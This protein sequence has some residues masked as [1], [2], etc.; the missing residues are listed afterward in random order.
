[1]YK[2]TPSIGHAYELNAPG[3]A[4]CKLSTS[5]R[6]SVVG[7]AHTVKLQSNSLLRLPSHSN[8]I[9][10]GFSMYL[11]STTTKTNSANMLSFSNFAYKETPKSNQHFFD[12]KMSW[13]TV[14]EIW[15][16]LLCK[17]HQ[18]HFCNTCLSEDFLIGSER[19]NRMAFDIT[20]Y[21]NQRPKLCEIMFVGQ[22]CF[23]YFVRF[24]CI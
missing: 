22:V 15:L 5:N 12:P 2:I 24:I 6:S 18:S 9:L 20:K 14:Y 16:A 11:W 17:L 3:S 1:M 23:L 8:R 21:S 7:A 4:K 19:H 10:A 13:L